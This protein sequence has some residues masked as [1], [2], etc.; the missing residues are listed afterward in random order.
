MYPFSVD[1]TD[2]D[3]PEYVRNIL[4]EW[5]VLVVKSALSPTFADQ[6]AETSVEEMI[7]LCPDLSRTDYETWQTSNTPDGPRWGMYQ[8]N[9]GHFHTAYELRITM[10]RY[11]CVLYGCDNLISSLD[12]AS[13][14]P[15]KK[16]SKIKDWAHIDSTEPLNFENYSNLIIQG[17]VVLTNTSAA[18]KCTPKSHLYH[19]MIMDY[20]SIKSDK[21]WHKFDENQVNE[22]KNHL[23]SQGLDWQVPIIVNKGDLIFWLPQ[24]IHSAQRQTNIDQ[25]LY[26]NIVYGS[27]FNNW[28]IV[29]Y[30]AMIPRNMLTDK[31]L[32]NARKAV[33]E[34][35]LTNHDLTK[36]HKPQRWI[37]KK[38]QHIQEI[39]KNPINNCIDMISSNSI[40]SMITNI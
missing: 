15:P 27:E 10:Y 32:N 14:F 25:N 4:L 34:G 11:Y 31:Q 37:S 29:Y 3:N 21:Q 16:V 1:C 36:I 23:H 22:I 9:V 38:D 26:R 12:G 18:F 40:L 30:I 7:Q 28:R 24:T 2:F 6:L 39:T 17:Q 8:Q 35:R 33:T 13:I 5:G 20:Y 19:K